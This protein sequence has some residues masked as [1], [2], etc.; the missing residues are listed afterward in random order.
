MSSR[1]VRQS[2][3]VKHPTKG[4]QRTRSTETHRFFAILDCCIWVQVRHFLRLVERGIK[5]SYRKVVNSGIWVGWNVNIN[6][7]NIERTFNWRQFNRREQDGQFDSY[8]YQQSAENP[9]RPETESVSFQGWKSSQELEGYKNAERKGEGPSIGE[10]SSSADYQRK[11]SKK[12]CDVSRGARISFRL[13]RRESGP[14]NAHHS[15]SIK[16][17]L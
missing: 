10:V 16:E 2:P 12:K 6:C 11:R 3:R 8:Y 9:N 13:Q 15:Y 4:S 7:A 5:K 14:G 1:N 17:H